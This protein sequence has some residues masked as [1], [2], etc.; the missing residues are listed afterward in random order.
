MVDSL[1]APGTTRTCDLLVRSQTLYPT[2]LRA[3][4]KSGNCA[5]CPV[6]CQPRFMNGTYKSYK[7]YKSH[8]CLFSQG[9]QGYVPPFDLSHVI[10]RLRVWG[11][12]VTV[13]FD[14]AFTRVVTCQSQTD[15]A[16]EE[17]E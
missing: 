15:V 6:G 3:L 10:D 1:D 11:N 17:V 16:V 14:C 9:G 5:I 12:R 8:S 13:F 7:T 4:L 2:E